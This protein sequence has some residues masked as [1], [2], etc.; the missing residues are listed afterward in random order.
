MAKEFS[1]T[2]RVAQQ[3]QKE[4][5]LILQ[6]E[7]KEPRLAMTTI[8]SVDVSRDMGYAKVYITF[9]TIGDQTEEESLAILR[10]K[11]PYIRSLLGKQIR[12]RVTPELNFIFD[13]SLT[14]GMRISNLVTNAVR[15]DEERRGDEDE[16]KDEE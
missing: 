5:A 12:L 7:L 9:L 11:A 6:R 4:L 1:R 15:S 10:E 16:A 14:E 2:Q 13:Q 3:L 8:S